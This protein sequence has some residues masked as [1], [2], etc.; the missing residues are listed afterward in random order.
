MTSIRNFFITFL[1]ALLVFGICAYYITG[2][3]TDSVNGLMSGEKAEE[4]VQTEVSGQDPDS[5]IDAV[6]EGLK[7]LMGQSFNILLVGTDYRPSLFNDYHPKIST[8][9]PL[10]PSSK[11]LIGHNGDLPEYPYRTVS[12]DAIV[13]V[14]VNE[15]LRTVASVNIP[16]KMYIDY[17]GAQTLLGDL[18]YE[19]GFETYKT[20]V[21]ALTGAE[22]DY[23]ALTSVEQV[24]NV[25]DKLGGVKF[26]VPCDMEYSDVLNGL[27]IS[28]KAGE[29]EIDGKMAA[30]M[31]SYTSYVGKEHSRAKTTLSFVTALAKKATNPTNLA[32]AASI[33]KNLE[34]YIYTNVTASDLT[35]NLELIFSLNGFKFVEMEYPATAQGGGRY[36]PNVSAAISNISKY[37]AN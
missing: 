12:A 34:K 28:L 18:Y 3:L 11:K 26:D 7:D 24:A 5:N 30:D 15:E 9:Y 17:A 4:T 8:Q 23:Y 1:I 20:K 19:K 6:D 36:S 13:L 16:S 31:L 37:V 22:I 10:F 14:C 25:V 32:N 33:F 27:S 35:A 2:F 29:T 21:S